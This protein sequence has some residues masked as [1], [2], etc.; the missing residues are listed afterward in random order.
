LRDDD[1]DV[2]PLFRV[3]ERSALLSDFDTSANWP[4]MRTL[5]RR[6]E[7]MD[8]ADASVVANPGAALR[9]DG[10]RRR[11]RRRHERDAR[12]ARAT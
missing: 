2:D 5:M 6:Y 1:I 12:A 7:R 9:A 3:L 4:R 11:I 10:S 8:L